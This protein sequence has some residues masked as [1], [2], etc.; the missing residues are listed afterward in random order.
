[1]CVCQAGSPESGRGGPLPVCAEPVT[2][3]RWQIPE[4]QETKQIRDD[5]KDDRND[6]RPEV[7]SPALHLPLAFRLTA[8]RQNQLS[9]TSPLKMMNTSAMSSAATNDENISA[10]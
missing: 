1:M 8:R 2:D 10:P 9:R 7:R 4:Q 3:K 6:Q 5:N